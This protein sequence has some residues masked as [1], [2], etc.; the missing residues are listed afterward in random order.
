[1]SEGQIN[2]V[3][4]IECAH[5]GG[6]NL[7]GRMPSHGAQLY[8]ASTALAIGDTFLPPCVW[9]TAPLVDCVTVRAE[10]QLRFL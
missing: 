6:T 3:T 2:E 8:D 1:M 10:M 4:I 7:F 5:C 9:C